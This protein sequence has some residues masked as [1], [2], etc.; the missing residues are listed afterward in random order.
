MHG[1]CCAQRA[2]AAEDEDEDA[3]PDEEEEEADR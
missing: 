3:E 2:W 1:S